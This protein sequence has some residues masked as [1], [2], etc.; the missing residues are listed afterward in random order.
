MPD[1]EQIRNEPVEKLTQRE[2]LLLLC[3]DVKDLKV[4]TQNHMAHH[5]KIT[6]ASITAAIAGFFALVGGLIA[7][8][9]TVVN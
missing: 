8:I 6:I 2:L 1:L 4:W 3:D 5:A 9:I 7:T